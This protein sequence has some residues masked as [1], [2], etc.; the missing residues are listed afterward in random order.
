MGR[1]LQP[2]VHRRQP[3]RQAGQDVRLRSTEGSDESRDGQPQ[4]NHR[5]Q[6]LPSRGGA[7]L[8]PA[9]QTH[10]H[11]LAGTCGRFHPHEVPVRKVTKR[12]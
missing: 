6:L 9:S 8:K 7:T 3:V 5:R 10:R 4:Q 11:R 12:F 2:R 1:R